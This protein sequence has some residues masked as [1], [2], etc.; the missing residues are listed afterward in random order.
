MMHILFGG[1]FDPVHIGHL[2]SAEAVRSMLHATHAALLPAA[3]SPLKPEGTADHHR[4]AMLQIAIADYPALMIDE[5]ELHRPPPSYTV[6]TLR[7]VRSEIGADTPLVWVMGV[8]AIA[9]LAHWK[10]WQALTQLAH[11]VV[12]ERPHHHIPRQGIVADWLA[13]QTI[14]SHTDQ[15]QC[16]ASGLWLQISLPPQPFSSTNIRHAL[17]QRNATASKPEGLPA[18]VWQYILD[19]HLYQ[20]ASDSRQ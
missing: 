4:L 1:S 9:G 18:R 19:H 7:E 17:T 15:L 12:V 2:A 14:A 10:E 11:V 6:D 8:D 5:R 3:R 20:H 13:T 16:S